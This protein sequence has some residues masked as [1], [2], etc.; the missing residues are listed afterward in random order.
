MFATER[1]FGWLGARPGRLAV[2]RA[3]AVGGLRAC[4]ERSTSPRALRQA[5]A[6]Q[7]NP[8][9]PPS[10]NQ[11]PKTLGGRSTVGHHALDVVIGVRIPASQPVIVFYGIA[12]RRAD[13]APMA[14]PAPHLPR[15]PPATAHCSLAGMCIWKVS[16]LVMERYGAPSPDRFPLTQD[17][18]CLPICCRSSA[19]AV[20]CCDRN[21]STRRTTSS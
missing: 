13:A 12:L 5:A 18:A 19:V 2:M 3:G 11:R 15:H 8:E 20:R 7:Y 1:G 17:S 10:R 9:F 21:G 14:H 6:C 4:A 16:R